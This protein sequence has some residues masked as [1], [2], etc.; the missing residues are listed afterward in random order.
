MAKL[1][2]MTGQNS[3]N[4]SQNAGSALQGKKAANFGNNNAGFKSILK[5]QIDEQKSENLSQ[6]STPAP[7]VAQNNPAPSNQG[8]FSG[9]SN[10]STLRGHM[11][12]GGNSTSPQVSP[13]YASADN[14]QNTQMAEKAQ[15]ELRNEI[16]QSGLHAL[17]SDPA[18][19]REPDTD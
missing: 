14:T 2:N 13:Q 17:K 3:V 4:Q 12:V 15:Q 9:A 6:P 8:G 16:I 10:S 7:S 19:R 5:K 1:V 11:S 18:N